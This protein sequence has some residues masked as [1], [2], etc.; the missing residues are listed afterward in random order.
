MNQLLDQLRSI[1]PGMWRHRWASLA[2]SVLV[3]VVGAIAALLVPNSYEATSRVY[4]DT[5]SILKP[6]MVGLAI[7]PNIEQQVAMMARTLVNRPNIDRVMRM[8]DLDL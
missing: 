3:G 4:V 8:S 5:Q 2:L 7:Q 6:L 1:L